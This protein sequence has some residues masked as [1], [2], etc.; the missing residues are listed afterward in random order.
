MLDK[1]KKKEIVINTC[2]G[3]FG[4]SDEAFELYLNKKGIRFYK[5]KGKLLGSDYYTVSPENCHLSYFD[6]KRDDPVLVEVVKTLKEKANNSCS[7]LKIVKIPADVEYE[8]DEYDGVES[9]HEV[10]RSWR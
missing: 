1:M 6:I 3:G 2:F 8:I 7:E 4:L 9:I 5:K 10:H